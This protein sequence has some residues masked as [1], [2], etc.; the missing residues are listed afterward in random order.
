M[1]LSTYRGEASLREGIAALAAAGLR[2]VDTHSW[3]VADPGR[4]IAA[5]ARVT[6]PDHVLSPGKLVRPRGEVP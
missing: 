1:V 6:D 5:A 4:A 2:V 3:S